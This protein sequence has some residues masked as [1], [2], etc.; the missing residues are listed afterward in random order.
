MHEDNK[1]LRFIMRERIAMVISI[2]SYEVIQCLVIK[3]KE[4]VKLYKQMECN[5]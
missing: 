1:T 3:L 4:G 2:P 5:F